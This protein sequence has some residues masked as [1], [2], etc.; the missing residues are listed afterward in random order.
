MSRFAVVIPQLPDYA[1]SQ[2]FDEIALTLV[3]GLNALGHDAV[4]SDRTHHDDRRCILLAPQLLHLWP[5]PVPEDAILYN[6]EQI[7]R[8]STWPSIT[9]SDSSSGVAATDASASRTASACSV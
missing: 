5:Q 9:V 1:H 3:E 4:Q 2:A 7:D 8:A 6:L